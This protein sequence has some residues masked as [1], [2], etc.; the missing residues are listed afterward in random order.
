MGLAGSHLLVCPLG[1]A[2]LGVCGGV[3]SWRA[4]CMLVGCFVLELE[5]LVEMPVTCVSLEGV[6][7][8]GLEQESWVEH[9]GKSQEYTAICSLNEVP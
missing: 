5:I 2:I 3:E 8:M 7:S 1:E 4:E 6:N 9:A